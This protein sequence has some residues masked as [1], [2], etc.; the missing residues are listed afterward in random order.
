MDSKERAAVSAEAERGAGAGAPG[1]ARMTPTLLVGYLR[2]EFEK[3]ARRRVALFVLQ[4][5]AALPGA[6][7]VLVP[8]TRSD[9][10]YG[11]AIGSA[12][13]LTIWWIVARRCWAA[14]SAAQAA[15]RA[16]LIMGGLGYE[17]SPG[18]AQ[19][20]R[21]RFTVTR[22]QAKKH[23]DPEYYATELAAGSARLGEML[24]ESAFYSE[25]LHRTSANVLFWMMAGFAALALAVALGSIPYVDRGGLLT[26]VR[27]TLAL[28]VFILSAEV[29]GG[30]LAHARA[31]REIGEIR[32]RLRAVERG[33][34]PEADVLLNMA[35]YNAAVEGAPEVVPFVYQRCKPRLDED[36]RMHL[37]DR[38]SVASA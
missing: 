15:R 10:L 29:I 19:G 23:E 25:R 35:D 20:L 31:A 8:D 3:A 38:R 27:V 21:D 14:R 7:A 6:V 11:L 1:G 4:F 33:G 2:A 24:E 9:I 30:Y 28:V 16:A 26:L 36:W 34:Y 5:L 22:E 37:A 17:L 13:L 12:V 18:E 32:S